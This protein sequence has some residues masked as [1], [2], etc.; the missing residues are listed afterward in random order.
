M[1][2]QNK[3]EGRVEKK[4]RKKMKNTSEEKNNIRCKIWLHQSTS[5]VHHSQGK[6]L[7]NGRE[8]K[9]N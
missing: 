7:Y 5:Y 2:I 8:K 1:A 9:E 6:N 3:F 4:E